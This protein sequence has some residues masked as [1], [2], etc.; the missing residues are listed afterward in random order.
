MVREAS[1]PLQSKVPSPAVT[2]GCG[3]II[4]RGFAPSAIVYGPGIQHRCGAVGGEEVQELLNE[5]L[6]TRT[7][8]DC[9][10]QVKVAS[11]EGVE[12]GAGERLEARGEVDRE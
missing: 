4:E 6:L 9:Q 11:N 10:H 5:G 8:G 3:H 12:S 2:R 1:L 7:G